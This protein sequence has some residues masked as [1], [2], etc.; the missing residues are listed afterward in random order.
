MNETD[1]NTNAAVATQTAK[2]NGSGILTEFGPVRAGNSRRFSP[3]Y[4]L[5]CPA[6]AKKFTML[7]SQSGFVPAH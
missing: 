6:C 7:R 4:S 5:T 2:C 3:T 1:T